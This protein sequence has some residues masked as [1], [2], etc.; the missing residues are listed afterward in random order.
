MRP[1]DD[2]ARIRIR[3][4]IDILAAVFLALCCVFIATGIVA[5]GMWRW[6]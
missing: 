1:V 5:I 4:T 3:Y 6:F 2:R